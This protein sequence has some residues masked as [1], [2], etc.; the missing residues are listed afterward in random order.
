MNY[1]HLSLLIDTMTYK[2]QLMSI[3]RHGINRGD[4]GPLA[5]S[6]FEERAPMTFLSLFMSFVFL[7]K[8][9]KLNF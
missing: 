7:L 2:G 1:R 6:S 8:F 4:V 9:L 3:D 5:K